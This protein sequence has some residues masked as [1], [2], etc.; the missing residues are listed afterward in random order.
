[1]ETSC[2]AI[3]VCSSRLLSTVRA[4]CLCEGVIWTVPPGVGVGQIL[5]CNCSYCR[6]QTGCQNV[7]FGAFP[8]S[9]V[10]L[11]SKST[12]KEIKV[13]EVAVR[14]FCCGCGAL[15][16]MDYFEPNTV[17][18]SFGL[19]ENTSLRDLVMEYRERLEALEVGCDADTSVSSSVSTEDTP[20]VVDH[21]VYPPSHVFFESACDQLRH[22]LKTMPEMEKF[23]NYVP[24]P[25]EP[26]ADRKAAGSWAAVE[27]LT[28]QASC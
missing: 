13:S 16:M 3:G 4:S 5:A 8:R 23:G 27:E 12:L 21:H 28:K 15:V 9:R 7:A 24:D 2:R 25:C 20:A 10:V 17:W 1:M 18:M 14:H 22:L 26:C 11:E 6:K 19:V